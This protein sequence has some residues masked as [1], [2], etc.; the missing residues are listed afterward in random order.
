MDSWRDAWRRAPGWIISGQ[1]WPFLKAYGVYH[2][3]ADLGPWKTGSVNNLS[4]YCMNGAALDFHRG[5]KPP[6]TEGS[7]KS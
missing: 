6:E 7:G 2:C 1:L 4:N 3:P 5:E